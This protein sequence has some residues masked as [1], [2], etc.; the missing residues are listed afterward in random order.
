MD[1]D[2]KEKKQFEY[3]FLDIEW[4]QAPGT[5][6]LDGREAIQ[7]GVLA[8]DEAMQKVKI[9]SKGIRLSDPNLFN[10]E[11]EKICHNPVANIM[12]GKTEDV[13]LKKL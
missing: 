3:L 7:I 12:Q 1:D 10:V 9:F 5:N 11:T 2:K 13:V 8:V 6:G 4:N